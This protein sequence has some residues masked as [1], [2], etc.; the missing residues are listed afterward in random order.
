M[1]HLTPSEPNEPHRLAASHDSPTG[2][3]Q[4]E[5]GI[6]PTTGTVWHPPPEKPT[7]PTLEPRPATSTR[8]PGYEILEELGRGGMG[9]VY[10]ARHL[11]LNRLV[12]MKMI[13]HTANVYPVAL[14]RFQTEAEAVARLRHP[15]IVQIYEIGEANGCPFLALELVEGGNLNSKLDG[16][17]QP[18]AEAGRL[19]ELLAR[20]V[21]HAHQ[22]GIVHR[23]LKPGNI[24]LAADGTPKITDFGLAKRLESDQ[25]QTA[26]EAILGTPTYMAPE[27]AAGNARLV[28]P[29][30][31]LY[32]LGAIL[33]DLLTGR[34]PLRGTTVMDTLQLVLTSEPVAPRRL[35]PGIPLDLQTIC[36][37]CLSKLPSRRYA[38][39]EHLAEDLRRFLDGRPILARPTPAWERAWKWARRRPAEALLVAICTLGLVGIV[40]GMARYAE[41]QHELRLVA[42]HDAEMSREAK[43]A[44]ER[45]RRE[46]EAR[47]TE[48]VRQQGLLR[49]SN[50]QT[51][52]ARQRA[53]DNFLQAQAA[54]THLIDAARRRLPNEPH[55]ER[56]R[57]DL[58]DTALSFCKRFQNQERDNAAVLLQAAR[59]WRLVGDIQEAFG[60]AEPAV[61][62]YEASE[63]LYE[64][65]RR[66]AP[67]EEIYR[68]ELAG[69]YLNLAVVQARL[70]E[71]GAAEC[72]LAQA[73]KLLLALAQ[74]FPKRDVH[75]RDLALCW[76]NEAILA[77]QRRDSPAA[78]QAYEKALTLFE[79]LADKEKEEDL[80]QLEWAR[81]LKN[82]G[83]LYQ[84]GEQLERAQQ[85]Y[86]QALNRLD[87]LVSRSPEVVAVR[88][89][90]GQLAANYALLLT[91]RKKYDLAENVCLDA[92]TLYE[93]LARD[94]G[95]L[96]DC[97]HLLA[98]NL[99]TRGEVRRYRDNLEGALTDLESA[100][101]VLERL[102]Q[103][104]PRR[105]SYAVELART[106]N[107]LGR[108]HDDARR[109]SAALKEREEAM[110]AAEAALTMAPGSAEAREELLVAL[111]PLLKW[112]DA[113]ARRQV[114]PDAWRKKVQALQ[115]LVELR[116]R[117]LTAC[118]TESKQQAGSEQNQLR[119]ELAA[120]RL[121]LAD[122]ALGL[123]D[124]ELAFRALSDLAATPTDVPPEWKQ[125]PRAA[126]LTARCLGLTLQ[127]K[128]LSTEERRRLAKSGKEL[129]L[130]FLQRASEHEDGV[131]ANLFDNEAFA[132]L[133]DL[134][135]FRQLRNRAR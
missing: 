133:R 116:H 123:R 36:L 132:P 85:F 48:A 43:Q 83:V 8:V 52:K 74:E 66:S 17:P 6:A 114:G 57:K 97:R 30:A 91:Q 3:Q 80:V 61:E 102:R 71:D 96:A 16:T 72:S 65:L 70:D 50:E 49:E 19:L 20:A 14:A 105:S 107:R 25:S 129:V 73:R 88:Q 9:V 39:A 111:D 7:I 54:V 1:A 64:E 45:E 11:A 15:N 117:G 101:G 53:E 82:L 40:A 42:E 58:L 31:D 120:T 24:L 118:R 100:R 4:V 37:K 59:T 99:M 62:A 92:I 128:G 89:E 119:E 76:N 44:A 95:S 55:T 47:R 2:A 124:R 22:Q 121:A 98:L 106:R 94:F 113:E 28:G 13:L 135:E 112:Y 5:E 46:V 63:G 32:A 26:S 84:S 10:K 77:Q 56:L 79:G 41:Q 131:P 68:S 34:P 38:S 12:A 115:R 87:A 33:Y 35:Q 23:D 93:K 18:P 134:F 75:R 110:K 126:L 127:E 29:A 60:Q 86:R 130:G 125:Y 81:T 122:A 78:L 67:R 69:T 27:Q 90:R 51:E 108:L 103:E 104:D 21:H 109:P